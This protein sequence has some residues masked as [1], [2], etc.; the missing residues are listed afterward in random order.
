MRTSTAFCRSKIRNQEGMARGM[1]INLPK[2]PTLPASNWSWSQARYT[3]SAAA[4]DTDGA[5]MMRPLLPACLGVLV[6]AAPS[7]F[8]GDDLGLRAPPGFR[9]TLYAGEDLA[10]DIYAMTLD[11]DGRVVVTSEGWIKR[12]LD[13]KGIGKA[14]KA[15]VIAPTKTGGMGLCFD[16]G[17]LYFCGDGWFSRYRAG[18]TKGSLEPTPEKLLPLN[19]SEHGGHAMRKGPD[20]YWYVLGGNNSGIDQRHVTRPNSPVKKPTAGALLRLPPDCKT[21]EVIADGFRNPYDFDFNAD[22]EIF[23][24]DSD[25]EADFFLPWYQPTRLFHIGYGGNHGWQITGQGPGWGRPDYY[26]DTVDILYPIGRGSPTG[27]TCYR[28]DQFP[29]RYRGGLFA[30][31]WTFGRVY[32]CPLTPAGATYK[33]KPEVFL[34]A[35]GSS[36]FD[37]TDVVVAPDGSLFIS[38]GGRKTRG[39]VY[40]VEYVGDELPTRS[41][42]KTDL[43]KVLQAPQPLDAWSRAEWEPLVTKLGAKPFLDAVADEKRTDADRVRAAEVLTES[44]HGLPRK[45]AEDARDWSSPQVRARVAWSIGRICDPQCRDLLWE[46]GKD[47]DS[48][49][50]L[51]ALSALAD[52]IAELKGADVVRVVNDNVGN[53]D[54]R[55]R[56]AAARLGGNGIAHDRQDSIRLLVRSL[57]DF[58]LKN[59]SAEVYSPYSFQRSLKGY[60]KEVDE[61]RQ[62]IHGW[63]PSGDEHLDIEAARFLAMVED[64]DEAMPAKVAAM[65]APKSSATLDMHYLI[66]HSRL[67][68]KRGD[69][70][71]EQVADAML[72]LD[73]KLE[74]Q[75]QRNKQNWNARLIEILPELLKKDPRLTDAM[76]HHRDFVRPAH[77]GLTVCFDEVHRHEA[78]RLFLAAVKKDDDFT[79]SGPLI[80]LLSLLPAAEVR[81]IFREQWTNLGLR[82]ALLLRLA[83]KPEEVDHE[84]FLSGLESGQRQVVLAC[85]N[86]LAELPRDE[87]PR[88]LAPLVRLLRQLT[89]E[90]KEREVRKQASALFNRQ[91]GQSFALTEQEDDP[92]ALKR[93]YAPIFG[94]FEKQYPKWNAAAQGDADEDPAVWTK[95]LQTV[96]WDKGDSARGEVLFRNRACATCHTGSTRLG[97]DLT[98]VTT[99]FSRPDLFDA[100]IFPSRDVAPPYRVTR[101]ETR[102]GQVHYGII[103][104]FSADGV[105]LQTGAATTVRLATPDIASQSPSTRSLMPNGLLKGLNPEDLADLYSYLQTLKPSPSH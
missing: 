36:G 76:L 32:F 47:K 16:G 52:H 97:P 34:E 19:F 20:G 10:N 67:R 86:A 59:P 57:G 75:A 60:E 79:W 53:E 5:T 13:T 87:E 44:F 104:F 88:R 80:D 56:Q 101:I 30:C 45:M 85:L 4:I 100:I 31:D 81:P 9:V 93:V 28:H 49:V 95:L 37:P 103:A 74:G 8:A 89:L 71:A 65:W 29:E 14:D 46:L 25:V 1:F 55:V 92:L 7:T 96:P 26:L 48:R 73:R 102:A 78:A 72:H 27:V 68:G 91:S 94:W 40:H 12:L 82:D 64:D 35:I 63:F 84:R 69:K 50:R 41:A 58:N 38:M 54:K 99:R 2:P 105:I 77:V 90:P 66:V 21:C 6:F 62:L 17:D 39:A 33:T 98:A 18:K 51:A 43:D 23:T 42:P 24:Y 61:A 70:A 3:L 22:G 11:A 83:D 15:E